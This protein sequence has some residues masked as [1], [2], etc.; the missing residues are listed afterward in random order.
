MTPTT[1]I[2]HYLAGVSREFG[3]DVLHLENEISVILT[4]LA[5]PTPGKSGGRYFRRRF[6]PDDRRPEFGRMAELPILVVLGQRTGPSTGLPTYSAQSDLLFALHAG[7]GEFPVSGGA[8]RCGRG[9]LV[10]VG[11]KDQLN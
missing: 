11:L 8:G 10:G 2:L 6:L 9:L 7:Q 4:A 5:M 3:L 1:P